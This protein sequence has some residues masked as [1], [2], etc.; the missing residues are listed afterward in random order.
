MDDKCGIADMSPRVMV[1]QKRGIAEVE[2]RSQLSNRKVKMR[3]LESVFRSEERYGMENVGVVAEHTHE[4]LDLIATVGA[5]SV[6]VS[7]SSAACVDEE[8]RREGLCKMD[9]MG[10]ESDSGKPRGLGLDLNAE[11]VSSSIN[12]AAFCYPHKDGGCGKP[13]DDFECASS[14][15]PMEERDSLKVWNEMKQ[16]GFLSYSHGG[17]PIPKAHGKKNKN[18]GMKKKIELAKKERVDRFA[19]IAAPTGL[20]NGLNPG[21]INHVR[22]SKQVHSIIEALVRSEKHENRRAGGKHAS[23]PKS[24]ERKEVELENQCGAGINRSSSCY[25]EGYSNT[26]SS[27]GHIGGYSASLN[28]SISLNSEFTGAGGD[29]C[30]TEAKVSERTNYLPKACTDSKDD[31]LALKLSSATA[32]VSDNTSSLSNDESANLSSVNSLSVKAANVASQ[33][34]ELLHQD[35][36]GRLAALK[37]SRKRVRAVIQTEFPCLV[38]REFSSNQENEPYS[39][40]GS[41]VGQFDKPTADAHHARWSSLFDQ[42]DRALSEEERQ[43]E[44]WQKEV[45]EMQLQCEKGLVKYNMP[46]VLPQIAALQNDFRLEK[47]AER[48]LAVRAAAAS[49]YSTCSFLSSMENTPCF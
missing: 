20:L 38:S 36:K 10:H 24:G 41:I 33:W 6:A 28:R 37:R 25:Q 19:K 32:I 48:D 49:I 3:D 18:D 23:Q 46:C 12:H 29:L 16:N 47:D 1:G 22:N 14:V 39:S 34:L 8:A 13:S 9:R 44:C 26:L 2:E 5:S 15:G 21:I 7:S 43:L 31:V 35:I 30:M 45:R 17:V 40:Q 4:P 27:S 11:D 42:M